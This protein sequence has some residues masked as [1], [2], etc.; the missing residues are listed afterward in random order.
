MRSLGW[1][2]SKW[3]R[4][5]RVRRVL[6]SLCLVVCCTVSPAFAYVQLQPGLQLLDTSPL[7]AA[8]TWHQTATT[9]SKI[10]NVGDYDRRLAGLALALAT[11]VYAENN[12]ARA[13][14]SWGQATAIYTQI[15]TTWDAEAIR[16]RDYI[17][18]KNQEL[19]TQ[20]VFI[21]GPAPTLDEADGVL[22]AVAQQTEIFTF[23]G[24]TAGIET[25]APQLAVNVVRKT[26]PE[27]LVTT[28]DERRATRA[29]PGAVSSSSS[30][31]I[32]NRDTSGPT[33]L[34]PGLLREVQPLK[35]VPLELESQVRN[36]STVIANRHLG[37]RLEALPPADEAMARAAWR[38]F[39]SNYQ[40]VTGFTDTHPGYAFTTMWGLADELAATI[41]AHQ[42]QLI[43]DIQFDNKVTV[44]LTT[45]QQMPLYRNSLPNRTY[46]TDTGELVGLDG[47]PSPNGSGHSAIDIARLLIWLKILEVYYPDRSEAVY[48]IIDGWD[49]DNMLSEQGLVSTELELDQQSSYL[50]RRLGYIH[51]ST[52]ALQLWN[53]Y[54][55]E[56]LELE[57]KLVEVN[58]VEL[59]IDPDDGAAHHGL[60]YLLIG[61]ELGYWNDTLAE[62]TQAWYR[63][64]AAR[65]RQTG[66]LVALAD[67]NLSV[68][69]WF[70]QGSVI[71][72]HGEWFS[73]DA[74]GRR[75]PFEQSSLFVTKSAFL[76]S[77][78]FDEPYSDE[79]NNTTS[80]LI[81]LRQGFYEGLFEDG[82][83]NR[84][85]SSSTNALV[86][87]SLWFQARD[88]RSF[89]KLNSMNLDPDEP[90][91]RPVIVRR[92]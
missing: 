87:E 36:N 83:F 66:K 26:S 84:T 81:D 79:L 12:D 77:R 31:P 56:N 5:H 2:R 22:A 18:A 55:S 51:Y 13:Y 74:E 17:A 76:M 89:L 46:T 14:Q 8:E 48:N 20:T 63:I 58:R 15:G 73:Q 19:A 86:L 72:R 16:Y 43:G 38:Y 68:S 7:Q 91:T 59:Q 45:L 78:L 90:Q 10:P 27:P 57:S 80:Q 65:A 37:E 35:L 85:I 67:Y 41:S 33:A 21:E 50:E 62:Q 60:P 71:G 88:R 1:I 42:L 9:L 23:S 3:F 47:R 82:E 92:Y 52:K 54:P 44:F 64:M 61:T 70:G 75:I 34:K 28:Q 53:L 30:N 40:P 25:T 4:L 69:P 11:K 29:S 49:L 24:P 32:S 39:E 6:T